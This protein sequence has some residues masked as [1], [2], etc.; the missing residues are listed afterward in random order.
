VIDLEAD[1]GFALHMVDSGQIIT[2]FRAIPAG[3]RDS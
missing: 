3:Q 2:H 1:P